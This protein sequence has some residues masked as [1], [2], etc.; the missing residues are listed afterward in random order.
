MSQKNVFL[1]FQCITKAHKSNKWLHLFY[2]IYIYSCTEEDEYILTC[3]EEATKMA[4][5]YLQN[6][7]CFQINPHLAHINTTA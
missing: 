4:G 5:K 6:K 7:R 3:T 2:N 1:L